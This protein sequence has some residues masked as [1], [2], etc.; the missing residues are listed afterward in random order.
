MRVN[1]PGLSE[2][3]LFRTSHLLSARAHR[4]TRHVRCID[5]TLPVHISFAEELLPVVSPSPLSNPALVP[6]RDFPN[7][8]L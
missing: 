5:Y 4:G 6:G 7:Q 3:R 2:A 8:N 1:T